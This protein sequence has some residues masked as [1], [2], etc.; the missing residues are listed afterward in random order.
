MD[1]RYSKSLTKVGYGCYLPSLHMV[2]KVVHMPNKFDNVYISMRI[3]LECPL[4]IKAHHLL[5]TEDSL[6]SHSTFE[7]RERCLRLHLPNLGHQE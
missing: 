4:P 5:S 6:A 7:V 2:L 3:I 1:L